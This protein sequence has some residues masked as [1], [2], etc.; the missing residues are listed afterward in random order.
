MNSLEQQPPPLSIFTVL[1]ESLGITITFPACLRAT[2]SGAEEKKGEED[3]AKEGGGG[4]NMHQ[5]R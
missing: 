5:Q 1:D 2:A 3:R 4:G